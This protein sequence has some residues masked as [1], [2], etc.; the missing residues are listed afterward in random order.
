MCSLGA[1]PTTGHATHAIVRLDA[2]GM[3]PPAQSVLN[4][5]V[6]VCVHETLVRVHPALPAVTLSLGLTPID[7]D[8]PTSVHTAT[9]SRSHTAATQRHANFTPLGGFNRM[10]IRIAHIVTCIIA[11]AATYRSQVQRGPGRAACAALVVKRRP[12][13]VGCCRC[14]PFHA[15]SPLRVHERRQCEHDRRQRI[16]LDAF[17][18]G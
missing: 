5:V 6:R 14:V 15:R 2:V 9:P 18:F 12:R 10:T 3:W 1:L 17:L 11:D 13:L 8:W 7:M 4:V 16:D